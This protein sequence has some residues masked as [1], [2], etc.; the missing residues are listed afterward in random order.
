MNAARY[1]SP[2]K[3]IRAHCLTCCLN[4]P[5]EV[6]N[7]GTTACPVYPLRLGKSVQGVRPLTA[8]L[9][10]CRDCAGDEQPAACK[11]ETCA[12]HPFRRGKNPNR[13]GLGMRGGNCA[14][15]KKSCRTERA[16]QKRPAPGAGACSCSTPCAVCACSERGAR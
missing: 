5:A 11:I 2:L 3:G 4:Q 12:L 7:C 13:A 16:I 9:E 15:L 6:K 1:P 10:R 8:I 14:N